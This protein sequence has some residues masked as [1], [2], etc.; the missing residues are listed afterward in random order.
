MYVFC[1]G[2]SPNRGNILLL[3]PHCVLRALCVAK[4]L[5]ENSGQQVNQHAPGRDTGA[6]NASHKQYSPTCVRPHTHSSP[7]HHPLPH[8]H[9]H[10]RAPQTTPPNNT[11]HTHTHTD[12]SGGAVWGVLKA[13]TTPTA[14][15]LPTSSPPVAVVPLAAGRATHARRRHHARTTHRHPRRWQP[16]A[17]APPRQARAPYVPC[18]CDSCVWPCV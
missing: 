6:E 4:I 1:V 17:R 15:P 16:W 10:R 13:R 18:V 5:P 7:T 8:H 2:Y 14:T 12:G 3:A 9:R 11:P